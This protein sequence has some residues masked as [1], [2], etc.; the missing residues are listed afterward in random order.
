M[1]KILSFLLSLC[2]IAVVM[3]C[4]A[5][6]AV[7]DA[8]FFP[9]YGKVVVL[10]TGDL[11]VAIVD[12]NGS[13]CLHYFDY[14]N[15][16]F[17]YTNASASVE[18]MSG[19]EMIAGNSRTLMVQKQDGSLWAYKFHYDREDIFGPLKLMEGISKIAENGMYHFS[20]LSGSGTLFDIET[21]YASMATFPT[22]EEYNVTQIDTNTHDVYRSGL[23][24]KGNQVRRISYTQSELVKAL[25][26]SDGERIWYHNN[27]YF[28]L[29][30][31][32]D[33]W[34]WGSN[35]RGQLGNGGQYDG[36]GRIIYIG[37]FQNG[38]MA[39]PITNSKPTKI[40]T[41]V[42]DLW[43][44]NSEIRAV[45]R[46]GMIWQ[47]GDGENITAYIEKISDKSY[48]VG[49]IQYPEGF[50]N[51]LG[52][53]P[54]IVTPDRWQYTL[55]YYQILC[56]N[57]GSIWADLNDQ[58]DFSCIVS[59]TVSTEPVA[60]SEPVEPSEP[61]DEPGSN[62]SLTGFTDIPSGHYCE[63]PVVWAVAQGITAGTSATTFSPDA[64][65]TRAQA[66]TFLWRAAGCP[67]PSSTGQPFSDVPEDAYYFN[68][69]LWASEHHITLGTSDTAFSPDEKCTRAQIVT[70]LWRFMEPDISSGENTFADVSSR[71]YFF[72]PVCWAI[73]HGITVGMG[74]NRFAPHDFCTRG[75]IVTFLYRAIG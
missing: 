55:D 35:A 67:T 24:I 7:V 27:A 69:V 34:S 10:N 72:L 73:D 15:S 45:D 37:E 68:A 53:F 13:L 54:R 64:P 58:G 14:D 32:G 18:L 36:T 17:L 9:E 22:A 47:W 75:Q 61:S 66:V 12:E 6:D 41:G 51:C 62:D 33:L 8:P 11:A 65:C 39:Y 50:P 1:K 21:N 59:G 42:E 31:T 25:D 63:E 44:G 60:P 38:Y 74:N 46:S 5:A 29:T 4:T 26:F 19:V 52:Y 2:I 16:T 57:D 30:A 40:L 20:A 23:Y 48:S 49:D 70:F 71:D 3:P 56:R 43:F 28:V